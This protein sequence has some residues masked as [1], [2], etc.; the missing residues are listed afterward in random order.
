MKKC[1]WCGKNTKDSH[2]RDGM[3]AKCWTKYK[4]IG[5]NID[6]YA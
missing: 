1:T 4:R 6:K 5:K 3:C 2:K